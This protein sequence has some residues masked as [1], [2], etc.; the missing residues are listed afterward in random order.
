VGGATAP[1]K[2]VRV[3]LVVPVLRLQFAQAVQGRTELDV[4]RYT[5]LAKEQAASQQDLDN[6]VQSRQS[7]GGNSPGSN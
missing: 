7:H 1:S 6:A 2:L 3:L 5:P 4:N